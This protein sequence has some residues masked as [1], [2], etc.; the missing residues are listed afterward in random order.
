[1][2][3]FETDKEYRF[4]NISIGISVIRHDASEVT[5]PLVFIFDRCLQPILAIE[6][7]NY[8]ALVEPMA[9]LVLRFHGKREVLLIGL[10][11]EHGCIIVSEMIIRSLPKIRFRL[12]DDLYFIVRDAIVSRKTSPF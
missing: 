6:I 5:E 7:H 2:A 3:T 12:G 10:C 8:S 11:L 1:M 9:A 4:G